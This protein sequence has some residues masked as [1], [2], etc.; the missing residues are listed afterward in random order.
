[1]CECA[2]A[3]KILCDGW[4]PHG[5]WRFL[6]CKGFKRASELEFSGCTGKFRHKWTERSRKEYG[7]TVIAGLDAP[8]TLNFL[9]PLAEK[10]N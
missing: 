2:R 8:E 10:N 6:S 1:M 3:K 5:T 4:T 9:L 7:W